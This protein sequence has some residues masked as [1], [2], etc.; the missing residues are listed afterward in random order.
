[1]RVDQQRCY[2]IGP[3]TGMGDKI[4][5]LLPDPCAAPAPLLPCHDGRLRPVHHLQSK[6]G[7]YFRFQCRII[8]VLYDKNSLCIKG[9][10]QASFIHAFPQVRANRSP[11][12]GGHQ[13]QLVQNG[14]I[15]TLREHCQASS[16]QQ[17]LA[18]NHKPDCYNCGRQLITENGVRN[19][20]PQDS[21]AD[22][23][24]GRPGW[25]VGRG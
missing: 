12:A 23:P 8:T 21:Q 11:Q 25:K 3:N 4:D 7:F 2:R 13:K 9:H 5:Q 19:G 10:F 24:E 16:P 14:D 15:S 6:E 20:M 18:S 22:T 17:R 1:M